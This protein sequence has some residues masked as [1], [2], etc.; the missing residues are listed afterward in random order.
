MQITGVYNTNN[1]N[2][3]T[4]SVQAVTANDAPAVQ[5]QSQNN[6]AI[7][8]PRTNQPAVQPAVIDDATALRQEINILLQ[9]FSEWVRVASESK[10]MELLYTLLL[11]KSHESSDLFG[12][13]M[14]IARRLMRGED[15]SLE[16]MRLLAEQN[17]LLYF[18]VVVLK[19]ETQET[20]ESERRRERDRRSKDRRSRARRRDYNLRSVSHPE[21]RAVERTHITIPQDIAKHVQTLIAQKTIKISYEITRK[22]GNQ[23]KSVNTVIM[24]PH[25]TATD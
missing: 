2:I 5:V 8:D 19:D 23:P 17:P 3:T 6:T 24:N 21:A 1:V 14:D 20:D 4:R 9:Q 11:K 22:A 25:E 7:N 10:R 16:E 12:T 13:I 15:V 18:A